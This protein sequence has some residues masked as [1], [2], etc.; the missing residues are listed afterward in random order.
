MDSNLQP[1]VVF[2]NNKMMFD[3]TAKGCDNKDMVKDGDIEK[4]HKKELGEKLRIARNAAGLEQWQL[5]KMIGVSQ[6]TIGAIE[7]GKGTKL[8][9]KIEKAIGLPPGYFLYGKGSSILSVPQPL[10]AGCPLISW[11]NAVNWPQNKSEIIKNNLF[12]KISNKLI[13]G[14]ESYILQIQDNQYESTTNLGAP[15]FRKGSY[16]IIDPEKSYKNNDFVVAKIENNPRLILRRYI[17]HDDGQKFLR[18]IAEGVKNPLMHL[19]EDI[20]VCGVVVVHLD[21]LL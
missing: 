15:F 7:K 6:Q 8:W 14:S 16:I 19:T 2:V 5:G 21:F 13:L 10:I 1:S 20:Q 17:E 11:E 4:L 18:V 9:P 3:P 12:N